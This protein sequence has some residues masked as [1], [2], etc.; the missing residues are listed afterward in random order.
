MNSLH[1][2]RY[3]RSTSSVSDAFELEA[4]FPLGQGSFPPAAG[5]HSDIDMELAND[6]QRG[7]K[8]L[9]ALAETLGLMPDQS[10]FM[11]TEPSEC[12]DLPLLHPVVASLS[13]PL[14]AESSSDIDMHDE[15][16]VTKMTERPILER[17]GE[18]LRQKKLRAT[19]S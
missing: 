18:T 1:D 16:V 3:E 10:L 9:G 13:P 14:P 4:L 11:D 19:P 2:R 15:T 12:A 8:G 17:V 7:P 5:R 6:L